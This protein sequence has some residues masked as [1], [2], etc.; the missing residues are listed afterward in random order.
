M[1]GVLWDLIA[2]FLCVMRVVD[3][4]LLGGEVA[5]EAY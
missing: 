5:L 3:E 4:V 1:C 2:L